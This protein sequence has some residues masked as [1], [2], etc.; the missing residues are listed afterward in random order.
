MTGFLAQIYEMDF[1][2]PMYVG[3]LAKLYATPT[4]T[5]NRTVEVIVDVEAEDVVIGDS[6][7]QL[8]GVELRRRRHQNR[9]VAIPNTRHSCFGIAP[10]ISSI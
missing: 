10:R 1:V 6:K 7:N 3:E 2:E 8:C 9:C 5:S 4:F